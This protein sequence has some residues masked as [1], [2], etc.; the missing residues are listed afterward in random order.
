MTVIVGCLSG[1]A[2][3]NDKRFRLQEAKDGWTLTNNP[4]A[5]CVRHRLGRDGIGA[6]APDEGGFLKSFSLTMY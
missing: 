5:S 4:F 1:S 3:Y 2:V 6:A